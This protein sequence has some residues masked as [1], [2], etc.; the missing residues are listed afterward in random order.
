[1]PEEEVDGEDLE[2]DGGEKREAVAAIQEIP[3]GLRTAS[4]IA[5]VPLGAFFVVGGLDAPAVGVPAP[6]GG[7]G[8]GLLDIFS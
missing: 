7:E 3:A 4:S 5:M 8:R 6:E 1:M 2:F